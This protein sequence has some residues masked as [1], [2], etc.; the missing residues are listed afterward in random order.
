M[1]TT[2]A[3]S[4]FE[5]LFMDHIGK[6]TESNNKH[7]ILTVIDRFSLWTWLVATESTDAE[8]VM[9]ALW[10]YVF[11]SKSFPRTIGTDG[12]GTFKSEAFSSMLKGLDINHHISVPHHPQG[13]GVVEVNNKKVK[14]VKIV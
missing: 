12:A 8:E 11:S 3:E 10:K 13:H 9:D 5:F 4:P 2:H 1:G 7:Y 6:L 14:K